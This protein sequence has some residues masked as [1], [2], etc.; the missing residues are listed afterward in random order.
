[1]TPVDEALPNAL[2]RLGPLVGP[3][4]EGAVEEL[5]RRL[6]Q[7]RFRVLVVGEAKRGKS[8]VVNALLGREV[9]PTGVVPLTAVATTLVHGAT[10]GVI[11]THLDGHVQ[12]LP[13]S[14][15]RELVT[16]SGNP[17][18]V[19]QV[20]DVTVQ[21]PAPLLASGLELVDTPG[22][23]SVHEHNTA[24]AQQ[25]LEL[26]DAAVFVVSADPPI[27][28]SE[29]AWLREVRARAVHVLCVLN[30]ADYLAPDQ[31]AEA[32]RFTRTV[33]AT[34][35]GSDTHV[36]PV[37]ARDALTASPD[38]GWQAFANDFAEYLS[39]RQEHD[40]VTS[41]A[42][43]ALRLAQSVVEQES[44]RLAALDLSEQDLETRLRT[45]EQRLEEV[46]RGRFESTALA[47]ATVEQ[48]LTST[49]LQAQQLIS[50]SLPRVREAAAD[51]LGQLDGKLAD[52]ETEALDFVADEIRAVVD[53]W[54]ARH[55]RE[56]ASALADLD[57]ELRSRLSLH[58]SAV[59]DAAADLFTL[60]L[61]DLLPAGELVESH[62]FSYAFG[63]EIG[64]TEALISAVRTRLPGSLGRRRVTEHVLERTEMLLDRQVGRARS[65]FASRL[66]DS[67]RQLV[68]ELERRFEEGAGRIIEALRQGALLRSASQEAAQQARAEGR[69]RLDTARTLAEAL[70]KFASTR[71]D[72]AA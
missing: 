33:L 57:A 22:T 4:D 9:L 32:V 51:R 38:P 71:G 2:L 30:K 35:L 28:A 64:Q 17:D 24:E 63:P 27:S 16:E 47:R 56:L 19:K 72:A 50:S 3:A 48:L 61:P 40:L 36:W 65:D 60:E 41:V 67:Q 8:T 46:Q 6:T 59:R 11:V 58:I 26:M 68:R 10:D 49:T 66:N 42:A 43:R 37:S 14:S 54:R 70:A 13:L 12:K 7:R 20:A 45:F 29:R 1:V 62:R 25:A 52:V 39:S 21:L 18:N 69:T 53:E 31:L 5:R 34:E 23:G 44:A 15:L 55:A